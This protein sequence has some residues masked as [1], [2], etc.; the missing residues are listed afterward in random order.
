MVLLRPTFWNWKQQSV[1]VDLL[2]IVPCPGTPSAETPLSA[3]PC[4]RTP[5]SADTPVRGQGCP[6]TCRASWRLPKMQCCMRDGPC[7]HLLSLHNP[8]PLWLA[9]ALR[10]PWRR[11]AGRYT[12]HSVSETTVPIL[13][14]ARRAVNWFTGLAMRA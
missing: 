14:R 13:S 3:D 1:R 7:T 10:A 9:L 8:V 2:I 4:P 6:R 11:T 12:V 5:L